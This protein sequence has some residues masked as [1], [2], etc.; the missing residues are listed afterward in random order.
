MH[1]DDAVARWHDDGFVVLPGFLAADDLAA[2][3]ADLPLLFP[4]ADEFHTDPDD[5]R[6][7]RFRDEF[8]G[9]TDFPFPSAE[10]CLLAVH[11]DLVGLAAALLG[12]DDVRVYSIEAWAKYTGSAVYDQHHHR[13]YLNQT[14]MVPSSDPAFRQVEMFVYL[15][16]VPGSLGP[17]HFVPR[18]HA[19]GLAPIPNW[20][21]RVADVGLDPDH[22]TWVARDANP[23][24]YELEVSG[25]GPAGTVAAYS[26]ATFHRGTEL[27]MPRG[28]RFTL[29]VNFRRADAEWAI[30]HSWVQKSTDPGWRGFVALATPRQLELFGFPAPGHAFWTE[31]TLAGTQVRYPDLD[32]SPWRG[33]GGTV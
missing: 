19:D 3:V 1:F 14:L 25:A 4:T 18:R 21:P 20:L 8:G 13:D 32:L 24:L 17:P 30:R 5:P 7:A 11:D 28:A 6:F 9:I 22:P 2:G 23:T 10:L 12:T 15:V 29:H 26:T 33:A 27:T 16:D 31:E